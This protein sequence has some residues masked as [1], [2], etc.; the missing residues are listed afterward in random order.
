MNTLEIIVTAVSICM[1][2]YTLVGMSVSVYSMCR[3]SRDVE[4]SVF[5]I[6]KKELVRDDSYGY[7]TYVYRLTG[8][9]APGCA[10]EELR[11]VDVYESVYNTYNEGDM[12]S[13]NQDMII[14]R[15]V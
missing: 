12:I 7:G 13:L 5:K 3:V 14:G 4:L 6:E 8:L 10:E 15:I 1:L 2:F 9:A 11:V